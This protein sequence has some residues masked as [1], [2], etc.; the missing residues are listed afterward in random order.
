MDMI[1]VYRLWIL[2][3]RSKGNTRFRIT[4]SYQTVKVLFDYSTTIPA[5][6]CSIE[7]PGGIEYEISSG[8]HPGPRYVQYIQIG[9]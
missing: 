9:L 5:Q 6:M 4:F 1:T 2:V 3:P 8:M 7:M